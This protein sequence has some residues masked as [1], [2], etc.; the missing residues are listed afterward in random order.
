MRDQE[1]QPLRLIIILIGVVLDRA[2]DAG[3]LVL[4]DLVKDVLQIRFVKQVVVGGRIIWLVGLL[5]GDDTEVR[6]VG[7]EHAGAL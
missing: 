2:A 7:L 5:L 6:V 1:L 4:V 3:L